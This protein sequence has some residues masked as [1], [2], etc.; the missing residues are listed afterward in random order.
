MY[1][2]LFSYVF[3]E[4]NLYSKQFG[5]QSGHAAE[6]AT[7]KLRTRA[8]RLLGKRNEI[9]QKM[10]YSCSKMSFYYLTVNKM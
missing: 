5:F 3:E 7:V 6:H 4:K 2:R 8:Q 1:N 10:Q 9:R